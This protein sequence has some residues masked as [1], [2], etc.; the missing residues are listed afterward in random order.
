MERTFWQWVTFIWQENWQQFLRGTGVT[1]YLALLGTVIGL[2]IGLGIGIVRTIPLN[3]NGSSKLSVRSVFLRIINFILSIYIEIFRGT[4]MMVQAIVIYYGSKEALGIDFQA[5]TAAIIIISL[6]TGAYMSEIVRGG[7]QSVNI[8]QSEACKAIG[9]NHWQTMRYVVLPQTFRN[10]LPSIGNEFVIN[11][12][13][14]S[15]LNVITVGELYRVSTTIQGTYVR[16][17]ETFIITATI[18]LI[19]T[20]TFTRILRFIEKRIDGPKNFALVVKKEKEINSH[21]FGIEDNI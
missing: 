4:P 21:E 20:F 15:V 6:N 16:M 3:N 19:L 11:I 10:I 13:D 1:L 14:S 5:M 2:F 12:K 18:Y 7:I 9:M 8:G 17:Y